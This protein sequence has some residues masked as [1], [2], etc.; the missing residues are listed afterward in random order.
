MT[1]TVRVAVTRLSL[2]PLIKKV[3]TDALLEFVPQHMRS[4]V[5]R[6]NP[7][8]PCPRRTRR[9][10]AGR[11]G[12]NTRMPSAEQEKTLQSRRNRREARRNVDVTTAHEP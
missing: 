12:S 9:L 3:R 5:L 10:P 1:R 11:L 6:E 8:L 2:H 4:L 7:K